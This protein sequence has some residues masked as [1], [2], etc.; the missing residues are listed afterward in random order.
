MRWLLVPLALF[1]ASPA[2]AA[3]PVPLSPYDWIGGIAPFRPA[4]V[5]AE[6]PLYRRVALE[7]VVGVPERV[8]ATFNLVARAKEINAAIRATLDRS[9]LL[10]PDG[11]TPSTILKVSWVDFDL[12][13]KISFSSSASVTVRYELRRVDTGQIIFR[14]DV[15]TTSRASG[16]PGDVRARSTGRAAI[17]GNIAGAIWCLDKAAYG[18]APQ[19]CAAQAGGSIPIQTRTYVYQPPIP[20][21]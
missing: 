14:R 17:L 1:A 2:L 3:D 7:P 18:Q 15:T 19:N 4:P 13:F 5:A 21:R 9:N 6:H 10:A 8:G 12:P 20:T 16:G 11:G